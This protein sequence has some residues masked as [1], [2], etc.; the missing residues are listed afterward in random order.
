MGQLTGKISSILV[1]GAA[2]AVER[3][4]RAPEVERRD[5][6]GQAAAAVGVEEGHP[7]GSPLPP[8]RF[9]VASWDEVPR[10]VANKLLFCAWRNVSEQASVSKRQ[11]FRIEENWALFSMPCP[12]RR[13]LK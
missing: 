1:N 7:D 9:G 12:F 3:Q 2:K 13:D 6:A 4:P 5:K 11:L 10:P 8:S